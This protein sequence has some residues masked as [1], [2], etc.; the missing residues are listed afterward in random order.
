[1]VVLEGGGWW[2]SRDVWRF[3]ANYNHWRVFILSQ[4]TNNDV[5]VIYDLQMMQVAVSAPNDIFH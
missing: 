1:M 2:S 4:E 3:I 5:M